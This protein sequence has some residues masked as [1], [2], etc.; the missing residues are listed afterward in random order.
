MTTCRGVGK[1]A[2]ASLNTPTALTRREMPIRLLNG[3]WKVGRGPRILAEHRIWVE[4]QAAAALI[5][6]ESCSESPILVLSPVKGNLLTMLQ[7]TILSASCDRPL[8]RMQM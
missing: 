2:E 1:D 8:A 6:T 5:F 4:G 3:C 7:L